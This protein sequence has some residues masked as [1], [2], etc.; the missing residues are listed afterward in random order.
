MWI[1]NDGSE[2]GNDGSEAGNDENEA[3][4]DGSEAGNGGRGTG[5]ATPSVAWERGVYGYQ[6]LAVL[7]IN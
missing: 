5:F 3:G 7:A 2:A 6:S 4:N 1:G